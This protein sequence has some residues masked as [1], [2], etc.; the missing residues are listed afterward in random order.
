MAECF[1]YVV[2]AQK[3]TCVSHSLA[4]N[5]TSPTDR[6]LI[7]GKCTLIEIHKITEEGVQPVLELPI[8]GRI[9]CM[10]IF[11]PPSEK[12]DLLALIT[13]SYD[14]CILKF[15]SESGELETVAAGSVEEQIERATENGMFSIV[16]PLCRVLALH[17]YEGS[18]K[19][20]P[21]NFASS[22]KYQTTEAFNVRYVLFHP[23]G[24]R[25]V[26]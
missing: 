2:T 7:I 13:E 3:P 19:I 16:D 21:L 22:N 12:Q 9:A 10:E 6:N 24:T 26:Y 5:F 18:L 4:G 1:N 11:R 14:T 23:L 20:I 25:C 17:L 8:Y 15:N